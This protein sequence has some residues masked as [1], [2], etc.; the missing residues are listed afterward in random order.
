MSVQKIK[1]EDQLTII[2]MK[3]NWL[4]HQYIWKVFMGYTLMLIH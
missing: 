4:L 1:L 3:N 2:H